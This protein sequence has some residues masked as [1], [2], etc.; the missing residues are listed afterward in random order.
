[1]ATFISK[2]AFVNR[3]KPSKKKRVYNKN[4]K[5]YY[6]PENCG[7]NDDRV[8]GMGKCFTCW[9]EEKHSEDMA[10]AVYE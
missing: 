10:T 6:T 3:S 5:F 7:H 2:K 1:M 4:R 9:Y 8:T